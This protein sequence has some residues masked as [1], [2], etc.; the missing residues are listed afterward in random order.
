MEVPAPAPNPEP[1]P[2]NPPTDTQPDDWDTVTVYRDVDGTSPAAFKV[3]PDGV[4]T[5]E[6]PFRNKKFVVPFTVRYKKPKVVGVVGSLIAPEL[7]GGTATYTPDPENLPRNHWSLNFPG[8]TE[9]EIKQLLS[10][11]AKLYKLPALPTAGE[12]DA[13]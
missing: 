10:A 1:L 6:I 13:P 8:K 9:D 12:G 2:T 5:F 4:S 11:Y 7:G 3:D